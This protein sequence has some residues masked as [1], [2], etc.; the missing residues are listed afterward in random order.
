MAITEVFPNPTVKQ[1]IFQIR[2]P[3]LF[4]IENRIG[5][6]Q[7]K[8]IKEFPQSSLL[9]RRQLVF[10]DVG[11]NVNQVE[12]P[13][14]Y[15]N[16]MG[17]KIW[18]FTSPKGYELNILN[19]SLDISSNFHKTYNNKGAEH[20][21][22]DIIKFVLDIFLSD[23]GLSII[24]RIGLRYIDHCPIPKLDDK[25]IKEYYKTTFPLSRFSIKD[26]LAMEFV[27]KVK[28]NGYELR[29]IESLRN[30]NNKPYLLLDYDGSAE[31]IDSTNY[32]S[33]TDELRDLISTEFEKSIK[34]PLI[35][36][37]RKKDNKK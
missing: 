1:V 3:N 24:N 8:I 29:Y 7:S 31:K 4:Y 11:S 36:F 30:E 28:R 33:I 21:F 20:K 23:V 27:A 35:K 22:R 19:D 12:L 25:T 13:A 15:K 32:L 2:F 16:E 17:K 14:D 10:A 37:M 26:A 34:E 5:D 18:Q 9:V 6:I